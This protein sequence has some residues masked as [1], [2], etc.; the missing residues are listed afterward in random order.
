VALTGNKEANPAAVA[1][2][3]MQQGYYVEGAGT[4]WSLMTDG[5]THY[6][7]KSQDISLT[8][9]SM[10]DRLQNGCILICSVSKGDF[11]QSGHFIVI[12]DYED[13][14]FEVNDPNSITNS[15]T[16][17]KFDR[18]EGQIRNVWAL[19]TL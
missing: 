2:Y 14:W 6:G 15:N 1:L 5:C 3:S 9:E 18:L 4:S 8:E 17:W 19:S 7:L 10:V 12:Y 11:T 13:G 16:K